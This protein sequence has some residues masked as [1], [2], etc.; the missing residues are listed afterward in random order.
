MRERSYSNGFH[1]VLRTQRTYDER[2]IGHPRRKPPVKR[3]VPFEF[4]LEELAPLGVATRPMFGCVGVYLDD[5]MVLVLRDRQDEPGDNGVWVAFEAPHGPALKKEFPALRAIT[6][7][8]GASGWLNLP[9]DHG[10]FEELALKVCALLAK[11][12]TRIGKKTGASIR[13]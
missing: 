6:V 12:D 2:M 3:L 9:K 13:R 10:D 11:G 4:V 7:L 5:R 8:G 1:V